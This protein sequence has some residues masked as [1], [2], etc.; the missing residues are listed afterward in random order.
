[1]TAKLSKKQNCKN[2]DVFGDFAQIQ[3]QI[4]WLGFG[5]NTIGQKNQIGVWCLLEVIPSEMA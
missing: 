3:R 5:T 1:M 4:N 2:F